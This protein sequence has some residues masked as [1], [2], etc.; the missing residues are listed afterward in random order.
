MHD[1]IHPAGE[2]EQAQPARSR[3]AE[4]RSSAP[5]PSPVHSSM[6]CGG[7]RSVWY[8]PN[9]HKISGFASN[10]HPVAPSEMRAF[11]FPGPPLVWTFQ[12][13]PTNSGAELAQRY[14]QHLMTVVSL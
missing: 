3:R 11:T 9:F 4:V 6:E 2:R 8:L 5:A 13:T 12:I 14:S 7:M 1:N 10:S